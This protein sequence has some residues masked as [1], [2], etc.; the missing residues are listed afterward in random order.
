MDRLME[1]GDKNETT[2]CENILSDL[3]NGRE[4]EQCLNLIMWTARFDFPSLSSFAD[5]GWS[6]LLGSAEERAV[7]SGHRESPGPPV[8]RPP[9]AAIYSSQE[10][11][12]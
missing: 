9:S 4:R 10:K 8:R 2:F 3:Q 5:S 11:P 1:T 12:F 7:R 6:G